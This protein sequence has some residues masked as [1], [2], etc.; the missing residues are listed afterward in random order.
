MSWYHLHPHRAQCECFPR[1]TPSRPGDVTRRP[2]R[3]SPPLLSLFPV[4]ARD[5]SAPELHCKIRCA[6]FHL[7]IK[8][9]LYNTRTEEKQESVWGHLLTAFPPEPHTKE[10]TL[11]GRSGRVLPLICRPAP[12]D[13]ELQPP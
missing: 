2:G 6:F 1:R 5:L 13:L 4:T 10:T 8:L 9:P 3:L 11:P 12:C 7:N